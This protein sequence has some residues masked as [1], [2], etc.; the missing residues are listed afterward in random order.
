M[1]ILD[2]GFWILDFEFNPKLFG[3]AEQDSNLRPLEPDS[4]TLIRR[5]LQARG[6][7]GCLALYL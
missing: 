7:Q 2:F 5:P 4:I 3:V 1:K 6:E